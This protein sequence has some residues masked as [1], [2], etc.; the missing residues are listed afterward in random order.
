MRIRMLDKEY[1]QCQAFNM[2]SEPYKYEG[3]KSMLQKSVIEAKLQMISQKDLEDTKK[4]SE[5]IEEP[6]KP[7]DDFLLQNYDQ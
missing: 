4:R 5:K 6:K 3:L 7:D 2:K 1:N